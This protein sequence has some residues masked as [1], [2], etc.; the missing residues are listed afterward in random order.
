MQLFGST[1][2]PFV[3][4]CRIVFD[5]TNQAFE[6]KIVDYATSAKESP[7]QKVPYLIDGNTTL[8]DSSSI[9]MYLRQAAGTS[10]P[11]SV[12]DFEL[13]TLV[14]TL[15]DTAINLFLLEK[16]GVTVKQSAYLQRQTNRLH[17]G[18]K[19]LDGMVDPK[20]SITSDGHIRVACVVDWL[21]FRDRF[22]LS[23]FKQ[24]HA[25]LA[26][27]NENAIFRATDPRL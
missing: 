21:L 9:I 7:V 3:R 8:T 2:S 16:D 24:L 27:A 1:T 18:F 14:N 26:H 13:F 23:E 11:Y 22:D 4:H 19:A 6:L 15:A 5:Q 10:F 12:T 17:T 20:Q 25:L